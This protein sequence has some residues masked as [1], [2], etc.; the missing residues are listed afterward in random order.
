MD[1]GRLPYHFGVNRVK[2]VEQRFVAR[3]S[4]PAPRHSVDCLSKDDWR[5]PRLFCRGAEPPSDL[6]QQGSI[7]RPRSTADAHDKRHADRLDRLRQ[8]QA[9]KS[10]P[11]EIDCLATAPHVGSVIPVADGPIEFT[12]IIGMRR[13]GLA[14]VFDQ[15]QDKRPISLQRM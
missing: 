3:M 12:K 14:A 7:K 11:I 1:Q 15:S 10:F 5:N 6:D 13:D 8:R 4:A 9:A 2:H